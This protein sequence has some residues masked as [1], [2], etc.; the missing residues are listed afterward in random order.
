[1]NKLGFTNVTIV[2]DGLEC[3]ELFNT[4]TFDVIFMDMQ[5][6]RLDGL[7]AT[8][9]IRSLNLAKPPYIIALTANAFQE[10]VS[11]CKEV[12]MDDFLAKPLDTKILKEKIECLT[13][14]L[15]K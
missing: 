3:V 2:N 8:R 15:Q 4:Q 10:D 12:G 6:P 11:L 1:L 14:L 7:D 9:I 13:A 5:M